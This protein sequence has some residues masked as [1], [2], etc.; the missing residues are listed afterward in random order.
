[1]NFPSLFLTACLW[2]FISKMNCVFLCLVISLTL[3]TH[4]YTN[5]TLHTHTTHHTLHTHHM[6]TTYITHITC[7]THTTCA[8]HTSHTP[9]ALHIP[10]T[11]FSHSTH[12]THTSHTHYIHTARMPHTTNMHRTYNM[13]AS[14]KAHTYAYTPH[15]THTFFLIFY[16]HLTITL[17]GRRK[18]AQKRKKMSKHSFAGC[19]HTN[20]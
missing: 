8:R 7:F 13:H 4:Q 3:H 18:M 2:S 14:Y 6:C 11:C 19:N 16:P 17:P 10:H 1:M 12:I 5:H 9:L 15:I 20:F